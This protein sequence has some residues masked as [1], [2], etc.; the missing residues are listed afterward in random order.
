[1]SACLLGH[2]K[3]MT[4]AVRKTRTKN[5]VAFF[6]PLNLS[7]LLKGLSTDPTAVILIH[8]RS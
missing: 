8:I 3:R 7:G 5:Q 2:S 4:D 1:M 6:F